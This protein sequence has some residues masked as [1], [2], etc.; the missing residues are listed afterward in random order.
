MCMIPMKSIAKFSN[1]Y[2]Q[3]CPISYFYPKVVEQKWE[4]QL[5]LEK[6]LTKIT[7]PKYVSS[8]IIC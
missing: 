4:I 5:S 6:T 3:L 2:T 7:P 1:D 8:S